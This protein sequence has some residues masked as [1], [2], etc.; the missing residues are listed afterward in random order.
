MDK[1]H[2]KKIRHFIYAILWD[3]DGDAFAF[4]G[5]TTTTNTKALLRR[6]LRGEVAIT[7]SELSRP[8]WGEKPPRLIVLH[9]L[10]CTGAEAYKYILCYHRLYEDFGFMTVAYRGTDDQAYDMLP[11]TECLYTGL[12]KTVTREFLSA[13]IQ[14]EQQAGKTDYEPK[15]EPTKQINMRLSESALAAFQ[16]F[17]KKLGLTQKEGFLHLMRYMNQDSLDTDPLFVEQRTI[18]ERQKR[19]IKTLEEK[20]QKGSRDQEAAKRVKSAI[21]NIKQFVAQ[22]ISNVVEQPRETPLKGSS[23]KPYLELK[24]YEYPK[25]EGDTILVLHDLYYSRG[26]YPA[27]F[28]CGTDL[29]N[30]SLIKLRY[31]PRGNY[32]GCAPGGKY[33]VEN[34]QWLVSFQRTRDDAM[35]LIAALPL[36]QSAESD[37]VETTESSCNQQWLDEVIRKASK[38]VAY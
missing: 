5:K 26:K 30:G 31:Y 32:I 14:T 7:A 4:V 12:Q 29:S 13:G 27:A 3:D 37:I 38:L 11:Y 24:A 18:I 19:Y 1:F 17:C 6:H 10:E 28:L 16:R 2:N 20:L 23:H 25:S 8:D 21:A 33:C 34:A 22:Y 9:T 36:L 15:R 35:E